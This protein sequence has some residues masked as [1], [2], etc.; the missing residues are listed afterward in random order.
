MMKDNE[1]KL[2]EVDKSKRRKW[3]KRCKKGEIREG[4]GVG[5]KRKERERKEEGRGEKKRKIRMDEVKEKGVKKKD[6]N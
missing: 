3:D 5:D 4:R 2:K 6:E 1:W